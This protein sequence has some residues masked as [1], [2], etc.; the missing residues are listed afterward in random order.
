MKKKDLSILFRMNSKEGKEI[1]NF[2][3]ENDIPIHNL[4]SIMNSKFQKF[5]D[6]RKRPLL[7]FILGSSNLSQRHFDQ[8]KSIIGDNTFKSLDFLVQVVTGDI[9][10][11]YNIARFLR[12]KVTDNLTCIVPLTMSG[13]GT[14]LALSSNEIIGGNTTYIIPPEISSIHPSIISW[15]ETTGQKA[16]MYDDNEK[17]YEKYQPE[18]IDLAQKLLQDNDAL[19]NGNT[20]DILK[21]L[22]DSQLIEIPEETY[23]FKTLIELGINARIANKKEKKSFVDLERI[24]P[25]TFDDQI[26]LIQ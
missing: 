25:Q 10:V 5:S 19:T 21:H 14:L 11:A 7:I 2:M 9:D 6:V 1:L 18:A 4:P 13:A 8:M 23:R 24:I 17:E 12:S 22:R 20:E 3:K 16:P 26:L 15:G